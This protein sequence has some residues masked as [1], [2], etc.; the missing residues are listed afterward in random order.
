MK[1]VICDAFAPV[2]ALKISE[3][4]VRPVGP[5][6]VLIRALAAGVNFP[7]GLM[8][9]GK[10]QTKPPLPFTP[11]SEVAGYVEQV[12]DEV[13][14]FRPGDLVVGFSG[15]G[16][17]AEFVTVP[18]P[19][20]FR[21][22]EGVDPIVASGILITYGTSY[23]ALKDRAA[24]APGETLLVLGAAGG[25]GLAAVELGALMGARVIAAASTP[26]KLELARSY[27]A[28]EVIN[29]ATED[30]RER[31]KVL[32]GGK[33]V[34]VVYDPVGGASTLTAVKSLAWGGRLLVVGFAGGDI[35]DIPA[36]LL[37]LK[38][39]SALGVL[40]GMSLRA[41]P[42]HHAANI[43]DIVGWLAAGKIRPAIDSVL[44]LEQAVTAI[45]HVMERRAQG[46]V[47][48]VIKGEN[49]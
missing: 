23:H 46:K 35:P 31:L 13:S 4:S 3:T 40:W 11:G 38:S 41:D 17:F 29:Y 15:T 27:G 30:L 44:P 22:P 6:D 14:A 26:E 36:N 34:D 20:V 33:G 45:N 8:V 25:V 9:Q 16:A 19:Q 47:I 48:L 42:A 2:D 12:G 43:A 24:L 28:A 21:L 10:Y 39:A 37:L 18:A 49:E 5:G 1:A 32:T 7:D